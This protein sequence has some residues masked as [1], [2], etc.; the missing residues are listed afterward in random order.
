MHNEDNMLDWEG[1]MKEPKH[2]DQQLVLDEILDDEA[3]ASS[4]HMTEE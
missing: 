2:C 1:N 3:M 4:L